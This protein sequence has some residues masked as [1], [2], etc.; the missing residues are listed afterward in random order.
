[1][2]TLSLKNFRCWENQIFTFKDK[3]IILLSGI[4]GKGKSTIL[5]AILYLITGNMKNIVTSGKDTLEVSLQIDNITIT[6][7]KPTRFTV[8]KD[9]II[10]EEDEAQTIIN[11]LFGTDFKHTSYIDQDNLYSF[12]YLSPESK[13]T[14]LRNLLL[15]SEKIDTLKDRIKKNLDLS[16]KQVI[17]E[18]SKLS[19][20]QSFSPQPFDYKIQKR[21]ISVSNYQETLQHQEQNI[22]TCIKNKKKLQSKLESLEEQY[23]KYLQYS[24]IQ[25][26]LDTFSSIDIIEQQLQDLE[27]IK[28][29]TEEIEKVKEWNKL[30]QEMKTYQPSEYKKIKSFERFL[31]LEKSIIILEEK[32][33]EEKEEQLKT[34]LNQILL[35]IEKIKIGNVYE[36]PQCSSHLFLKNQKL[37]KTENEVSIID[38]SSS[39]LQKRVEQIQK[40]LTMLSHYTTEYNTLFDE[41]ESF[42]F[43]PIDVK[44]KL[45]IYKKEERS[46]LL[47]QTKLNQLSPTIKDKDIEIKDTRSIIEIIE[48]ISKLKQIIKRYQYLISEKKEIEDPSLIL[49]DTKEKIIE[50]E[51]K[52]E[53]Y[54]THISKLKEWNK[55]RELMISIQS[56]KDAKEYYME[57]V[58]CYEKLQHYVKEAETKSIIDF[59]E[60]LNQHAQLYIE[61]FFKDEDIQVQL[62]TN[63]ELKSGKDKVGLFFKV[64]YKKMEGDIDFLSGGQRDRINL[65]FTLAFSELVDNRI[66]L[67]DECISSLDSETTDIVIETLKE[68][69]KGKLIICVAHQVNTGMFDEV[70]LV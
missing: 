64:F 39:I 2:I 67:L 1:M 24:I 40:E 10:Y 53:V 41:F 34:E 14:F 59:I 16:K 3:G 6:R 9:D 58:K 36:C 70:I 45:E 18:D 48:D 29:N 42:S 61:D 11:N 46:F 57:E 13:M 30:Q 17:Q 22:E 37:L 23:K 62:T 12:V 35:K 47:L 66:L 15:H 43:D 20:F 32:I 65:A 26:E 19:T 5:N 50:I 4:S 28:K 63:K 7:S 8:K 55:Q 44:H 25:K 51:E 52:I 21:V 68:K 69:Y 27:E 56:A 33:G 60:S 54:S 31:E 38:S 49:K